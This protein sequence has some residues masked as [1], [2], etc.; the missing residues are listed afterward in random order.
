MKSIKNIVGKN[1]TNLS[2]DFPSWDYYFDIKD[3]CWHKFV[4]LNNSIAGVPLNEIDSILFNDYN[5]GY[6][7]LLNNSIIEKDLSMNDIVVNTRLRI[8][9]RHV[10]YIKLNRLLHR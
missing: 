2:F 8:S 9:Y 1:K 7:K 3:N 5:K 10:I 6:I 4:I